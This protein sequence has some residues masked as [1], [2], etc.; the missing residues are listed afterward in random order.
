MIWRTEFIR[1]VN[2]CLCRSM[3]QK[4]GEGGTVGPGGLL[5]ENSLSSV[6]EKQQDSSYFPE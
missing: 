6:C 5:F 3:Q 1:I 4:V 2:H